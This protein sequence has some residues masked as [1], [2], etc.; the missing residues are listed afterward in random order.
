MRKLTGAAAFVIGG[1]LLAGVAAADT[2]TTEGRVEKPYKAGNNI[3]LDLS[4][5]DYTVQAGSSDKIVVRYRVE[6]PS[7]LN[8]VK[9]EV[10]TGTPAAKIYVDGPHRNFTVTIELPARSDL[11]VRLSAGDITVKGIE[12]NKDIECHAGDMDIY[13][14][15]ADDYGEV[16]A[17]VRFGDLDA[18]AFKVSKGGIGRS[19]SRQGPGKYRLHAHLGAGDLTLH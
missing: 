5:G 18:P 19:F 13:V 17:S 8:K 3:K 12:G 10:L 2:G 15:K 4:A 7:E 14:G 9:V 11:Y 1:A 6:E 16:D